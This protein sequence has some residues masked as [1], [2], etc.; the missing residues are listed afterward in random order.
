[1]GAAQSFGNFRQSLAHDVYFALIISY[2]AKQYT[3]YKN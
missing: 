1:M 3:S 2:V